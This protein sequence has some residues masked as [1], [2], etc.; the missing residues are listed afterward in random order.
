MD[1]QN[2]GGDKCCLKDRYRLGTLKGTGILPQM[3]KG[4]GIYTQTWNQLSPT[5]TADTGK[6]NFLN[7][8]SSVFCSN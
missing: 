4:Y 8:A 7:Y 5:Y 2:C 3:L 1:A 6:D